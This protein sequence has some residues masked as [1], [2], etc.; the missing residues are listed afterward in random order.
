MFW[1]LSILAIFIALVFIVPAVAQDGLIGYWPMDEGSG[2]TVG[3][4]SGNGKDGTAQDTNWVTGMYG[5]ALEFDGSISIVDIPYSAD[6]TPTEGATIAAWVFPT[7][8]TRSC[9][10]GQFEAYGLALN[11]GLQLKSVI[12]GG[13]WIE[14]DITIPTEEW[15]HLAMTWNVTSGDRMM[16]LNGELV[17]EK[18]NSVP[19]PQVQNNFGIGKWSA[20]HGWEDMFMG[21]IDDVKLYNRALTVAEVSDVLTPVEPQG[22]VATVWG[23]VKSSL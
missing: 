11:D 10:V 7:D 16:V 17:A 4:A 13:D 6:I 20:N 18:A 14:A 23:S 5:S 2:D 19:V 9:V 22:K 1:K 15:S 21:I 8:T 3:D 12:W